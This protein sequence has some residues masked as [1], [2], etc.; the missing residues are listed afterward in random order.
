MEEEIKKRLEEEKERIKAR[1]KDIGNNVLKL[2][3]ERL[4]LMDRFIEINKELKNIEE[5]TIIS[6]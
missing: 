2:E 3:C 5:E 1:C 4:S 6:P